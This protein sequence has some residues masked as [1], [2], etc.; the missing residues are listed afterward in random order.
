MSASRRVVRAGIGGVHVSPYFDNDGNDFDRP[1]DSLADRPSRVRSRMGE[2]T[3][4]D[5]ECQRDCGGGRGRACSARGGC[6]R[7][8]KA[9]LERAQDAARAHRDLFA[10]HD[11]AS[12]TLYVVEVE[13]DAVLPGE[14]TP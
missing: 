7:Q 12:T 10:G 14:G 9:A 2:G 13:R 1:L 3:V 4:N 8:T 6:V 11:P 5:A